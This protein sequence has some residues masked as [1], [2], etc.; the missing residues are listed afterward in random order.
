M[1]DDAL[2]AHP[3]PLEQDIDM[4]FLGGRRQR[5]EEIEERGNWVAHRLSPSGSA[6]ER[7]DQRV[8][9]DAGEV[10]RDVGDDVG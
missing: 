6:L 4:L 8:E 2:Q 5:R 7:S 3:R 1:G 10:G 9:D